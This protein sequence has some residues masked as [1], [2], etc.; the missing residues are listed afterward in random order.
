MKSPVRMTRPK[1]GAAAAIVVALAILVFAAAPALAVAPTFSAPVGYTVGDSPHAVAVGDFNGDGNIDVA[2][3]SHTGNTISILLGLGN[4]KLGAA[5]SVTVGLHPSAIVAG[6]FNGDGKLDLA[7]ANS[8]SNTVSIL[9]GNGAG[10]FTLAQT[11]AVGADPM[12]MASGDFNSDGRLDLAVT[13]YTGQ[14]I[15][16][17]LQ[18]GAGSFQASTLPIPA[19]PPYQLEGPRAIAV[20]D[21]DHDGKLDIIFTSSF[22]RYDDY[23]EDLG[24]YY[25]DGTGGFDAN[26]NPTGDFRWF[27]VPDGVMDLAVGDFD[28]NGLTEIMGASWTGDQVWM[29]VE[30]TSRPSRLHDPQPGRFRSSPMS[31]TRDR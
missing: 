15:S 14:C 1:A 3:A 13:C 6:D 8:G 11:V 2:T 16:V 12:S 20:A 19:S 27:S 29:S 18:N 26:S 17:L 28:N 9:Y 5:K 30:Q 22:R 25:G 21:A 10:G 4:G 24:I 31:A 23:I 7:V